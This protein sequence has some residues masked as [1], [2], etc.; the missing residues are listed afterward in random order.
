M[1]Y[2]LKTKKNN[3]SVADYIKSIDDP[4]RQKD[5]KVVH[6]MLTDL[7]R[8]RGKMWGTSIVG[9][10]EYH[11][12]SKSGIEADWM[13]TGWSSRKA[14]LTLYVMPGY[15]FGNM[16]ELLEKLGPHKLGK[17]CLYIKHLDDIH[18]PTLKKIMKLGIDYM[19]K[20]YDTK[21]LK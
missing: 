13:C 6:N 5:A 16:K 17:S 21:G 3:A 15:G 8:S 14:N 12:K 10:G 1:A 11:Y 19:K 4:K 9:Y 7:T 18:L 2:E 20:K